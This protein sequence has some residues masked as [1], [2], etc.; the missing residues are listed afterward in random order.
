VRDGA[1]VVFGSSN[2]VQAVSDR[3]GWIKGEMDNTMQRLDL[4]TWE[5]NSYIQS[6]IACIEIGGRH[7]LT[8]VDD[9]LAALHVLEL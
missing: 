7:R 4:V 2:N 1:I 8:S 5:M 3:S 6:K 9:F